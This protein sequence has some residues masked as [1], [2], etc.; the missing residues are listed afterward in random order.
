MQSSKAR[1]QTRA[2][3]SFRCAAVG[4]AQTRMYAPRV[5]HGERVLAWRDVWRRKERGKL[6]RQGRSLAVLF[7]PRGHL[8]GPSRTGYTSAGLGGLS[9]G[10]RGMQPVQG[11]T[12]AKMEGR[13][14]HLGRSTACYVLSTSVELASRLPGFPFNQ[15]HGQRDR[16][17]QAAAPAYL[18]R[19]AARSIKT[20]KEVVGASHSGTA[21]T[22]RHP[23]GNQGE[24]MIA[25]DSMNKCSISYLRP[26]GVV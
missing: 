26:A 1:L 20:P 11:Q 3:G 13:A 25:D 23:S 7:A 2:A 8:R 10:V 18:L 21:I 5:K 6:V 16:K 22:P 4:E 9:T 15:H 17:V 12:A 14:R 24:S 19:S